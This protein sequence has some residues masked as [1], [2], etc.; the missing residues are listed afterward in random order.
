MIRYYDAATAAAID[1][2]LT[3]TQRNR[4]EVR[5]ERDRQVRALYPYVRTFVL[6]QVDPL[7]VGP[8]SDRALQ[9]VPSTITLV[10]PDHEDPGR[11]HLYLGAFAVMSHNLSW[12]PGFEELFFT[13]SDGVEEIRGLLRLT[14]SRLFAYGVINIGDEAFAVEYRVDPQRYRL[15]AAK[16]AAYLAGQTGV[17]TWDSGSDRWRD[18]DWTPDYVVGFTYGVNGVEII[19]D[20]KMYTFVA[21]FDDIKTGLKWQPERYGYSGFMDR[22]QVLAFA[23]DRGVAP[24]TKPG[25]EL[26][27]YQLRVQLSAFGYDFEG[28]MV[29]GRPGRLGTV[30]GVIGDW[31]G[32]HVGG[33][34]RLEHPEG[35]GRVGLV[36]LHGRTFYAG[37]QPAG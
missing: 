10:T 36:S 24:P 7:G 25:A 37:S 11:D 31:N 32:A 35:D 16:D 2:E 13:T 28:G 18:A 6:Q 8:A 12:S 19:G 9:R 22:D 14:H 23:L 20:E 30:Y 3:E 5:R 29:V 4:Q 21:S 34:Y 15:K 27:P 33:Q 1:K 26:F 17:I